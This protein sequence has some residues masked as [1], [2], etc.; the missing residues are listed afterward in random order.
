MQRRKEA[1][2]CVE[3]GTGSLILLL[4]SAGC[5]FSLL[6]GETVSPEREKRQQEFAL[7]TPRAALCG[8][9]AEARRRFVADDKGFE[10]IFFLSGGLGLLRAGI[11]R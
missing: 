9:G 1:R 8:F 4:I 11:W 7:F 5:N 10:M 3:S 6:R 2:G